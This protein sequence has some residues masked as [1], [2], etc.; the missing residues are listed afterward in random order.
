M[1]N[2]FERASKKKLRFKSTK[3]ML[4][5]EVLWE[6]SLQDL[7]KI[8]IETNKKIKE[9][10]VES[11]INTPKKELSD[12][13]LRLDILKHVIEYRL[14][15]KER[16]KE[17]ANTEAKIAQIKSLITENEN[18]ELSNKPVAD[19]HKMLEDLQEK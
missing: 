18:K 4:S 12:D 9:N 7:D 17:R 11:F 13:K 15:L 2:I 19:L 8:A 1:K 6:L 10:D 16:S 14:A 3:G 5:T